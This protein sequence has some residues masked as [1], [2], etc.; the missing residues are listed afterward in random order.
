M[1]GLLLLHR[2]IDVSNECAFSG[3]L[4]YDLSFGMG[5]SDTITMVFRTLNEVDY[6]CTVEIVTQYEMNV[7]LVV[8]IKFP[9]SIARNCHANADAF[10]VMKKNRCLRLCD[11][12]GSRDMLSSYYVITV[13][14]RIRFRFLSNSSI[15]S[16]IDADLY[17]VTVTSARLQPATRCN[18]GNETLCIIDQQNFCFT[19]GVVCDGIKNCGVT[20]WFDERK[21]ECILPIE[22]LGYAPV[23]AVIAA[24]VCAVLAGGHILMR[25][26]PPLANS[27]FIFNTNEDN[28]LC[29]DPVFNLPEHVPYEVNRTKKISVIPVSS[30]TSSD[31]AIQIHDLSDQDVQSTSLSTNDTQQGVK[32][33]STMKSMT[34]KLTQTIRT[35]TGRAKTAR[36]PSTSGEAAN[37]DVET[38]LRVHNY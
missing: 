35:V 10:N 14:G 22:Y 32:R 21:S 15:N 20:D 18:I 23:V 11:L 17:Q 30:S 19:S 34:A 29:I 31:Q 37:T 33:Q 2:P 26:L 9:T 16:D 24:V 7:F 4:R 38:P 13:K 12:I 6:A 27:F 25:C 1:H 5:M 28:R 3:H 36:A 8:V